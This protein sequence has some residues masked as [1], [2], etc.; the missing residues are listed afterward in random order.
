VSEQDELRAPTHESAKKYSIH[1]AGPVAA[2][3]VDIIP[4]GEQVHTWQQV[5]KIRRRVALVFLTDEK[6]ED[7]KHRLISKE[8][9]HSL[10]E[11][12]N[13]RPFLGTWRGKP[14]S[15][16]E[17]A[18]KGQNAILAT[19]KG[20]SALLGVEHQE[21]GEKTYANIATAMPL[22]KGMTAPPTEGYV[23][24]AFWEEKKTRYA[25]E[26]AAFK[27]LV[28][29]EPVND[30]WDLVAGPIAGNDSDEMPF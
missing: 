17:A 14:L 20:K 2:T 7:G 18:D 6:D 11:N 28:H 27:Q 24:P 12:S 30:G 21:R 15:E 25:A 16:N 10:H 22:M 13:L 26:V 1:P 29:A 3:C 9:T 5:Q 8:F 23:R 4:L 19:F